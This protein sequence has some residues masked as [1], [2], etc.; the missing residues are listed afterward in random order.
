MEE[1]NKQLNEIK[2]I[3]RYIATFCPL[4]SYWIKEKDQGL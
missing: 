1:M 4:L 3:L 2:H